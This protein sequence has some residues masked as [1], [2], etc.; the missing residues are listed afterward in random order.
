MRQLYTIA[1]LIL[2]SSLHAQSAFFVGIGKDTSEVREF[3]ASRSYLQNI[4]TDSVHIWTGKIVPGQE[5]QYRFHDGILY[6]IED[7]RSFSDKLVADQVESSCLAY[8]KLLDFDTRTLSSSGG[9]THYV[10]VTYD[11]VVEFIR[12]YDKDKTNSV[13]QLRVTSRRYGPRMRTESF[14]AQLNGR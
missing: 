2:A 13:C 7:E 10:A 3:L 14:V 9:K 6:A 5:I 8:L 12:E 11:Q 1:F 4:T